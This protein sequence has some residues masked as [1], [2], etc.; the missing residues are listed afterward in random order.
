MAIN[1]NIRKCPQN[2]PCP[3]IRV[4]KESALS[5]NGF[6]APKVDADKCI[7]CGECIDFCPTGAI[8]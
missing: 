2:H 8:Y 6:E 3:A 4:C 7:D 5:Q 1:I